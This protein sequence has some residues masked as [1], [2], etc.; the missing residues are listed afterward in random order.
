MAKF[1][2]VEIG[3]VALVQQNKVQKKFLKAVDSKSKR[4]ALK[5]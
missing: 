3:E 2:S 4:K 1:K 5:K